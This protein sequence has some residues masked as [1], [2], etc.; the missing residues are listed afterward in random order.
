MD[1]TE[2]T[3][4]LQTLWDLGAKVADELDLVLWDARLE[5]ESGERYLRYFI[6]KPGGVFIDDCERFHRAIDPLLD[7]CDPIESAYT[8]EVSSPGIGRE[9]RRPGH[10]VLYTGCPVALKLYRAVDGQ[11][12]LHGALVSADEKAVEI[13]LNGEKT[14][15]DRNSIARIN[16]DE[17]INF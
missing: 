12:S 8:L 3:T 7:E 17:E 1:K 13:V 4:L 14:T 10:F 16:L 5:T 11:K 15:I 2:K 9:L 6:D